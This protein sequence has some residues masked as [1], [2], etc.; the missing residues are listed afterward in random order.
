MP[1]DAKDRSPITLEMLE[2]PAPAEA[3]ALMYE[4]GAFPYPGYFNQPSDCILHVYR[5][6]GRYVVIATSNEDGGDHGTSVTNRAEA[7]A[8]TVRAFLAPAARVEFTGKEA[9]AVWVEHYPDRGFDSRS[10]PMFEESFD[11][12]RFEKRDGKYANPSWVRVEKDQM[13]RL[14]GQKLK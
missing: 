6:A 13:E 12:V 5:G 2:I 10:R 4:D 14:V 1:I 7:L 9:N 3:M 8:D 11:I